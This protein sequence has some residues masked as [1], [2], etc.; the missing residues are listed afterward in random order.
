VLQFE[1]T[2]A[3][4]LTVGTDVTVQNGGT[5]Q[6]NP[7]GTQTGHSL[8]IAGN[9]T[10]NGTL[11]FSTNADT[12]GAGIVFTGAANNTF[13]GSGATTDIRLLTINKG[14]SNTNVLELNPSNF[15]VRGVTTDTVVG[16]WLTLTNGTLKLS[17]MFSG[18]SRVFTSAAYTIATNVG[19]WLNNPNYTV[20]G[21]TGSSTLN[22]LLHVSQGTFNI[23]TTT[24]NA[25]GFST[26]S[27]VVVDGGTVNTTGRFG[28]AAAGNVINY[29]QSAGTITVNTIGN[30]SATLG[31][32]DLGTSVSSSVN[33]SG[34]TIVAQLAASA[35]DYRN[36]A[37]NGIP[38]VTGGTLQLG[39]AA[40]G[41]AKSFNIRGV[42]PNL[43]I[44]NTSANHT[45]T[46]TSSPVSFNNSSLDI[47]INAGN[48]L[49]TANAIFLMVGSTVTN[50]GTLTSSGANSNFIWLDN[51]QGLQTYTGTGVTTA[52]VTDM[53]VESTGLTFTSTNQFITN[54]I[55]L[56]AG[57]VTNSNHITLGTGGATTEVV[58]IGN[59]TTPTAAGTF[60]VAPVFNL[61]TGG[62]ILLY[63]RT[64]SARVAGPEIN[65]ARTLAIL[66]YDENDPTH[67]LSLDADLSVIGTTTL[68]NGRLVT[69]PNNFIVGAVARTN[70]YVDGNLRKSLGAA[71]SVTFE[72]GTANGYTPVNVNATAGTFPAS[73]TVASVQSQAPNIFPT[74]KA[75]DRYWNVSAPNIT[76]ADLTFSYLDPDLPGTLTEANLVLYRLDGATYTNL[77]GT[78][79]TA[80]NTLTATGIGTFGLFTLAEPGETFLL[81]A[82]LSVTKTDGVTTATPGGSVTYTITASSAGPDNVTGAT[83]ADTFPASLTCTWTCTG[84]G[85]GTCTAAGSGNIDDLADLPSGGSTTY[86]ASCTIS[87]TAT[88]TLSNTATVT[89]P[90][91]VDDETPANNS[92][93]DT[94]TLVSF[95]DLAITKTDGVTSATPGGSVTYTITASNA[96]PSSATGATIADTFP[97]N[98]TC[99]WTC[100][101]TAGGTCTASGAGNISD[102]IDLPSGG[103]TTY[104]ASCTISAAATGTLSNTAT[105]TAPDG[106]TDPTPGNNSA[107]D[108]D[109]LTPSADLA[110][111]NTDGVT[112]TTPHG[113]VTYTITASNAGPSNATGATIADTFPAGATCTWTC[114]GAGG[115]TC[116]ASGSGNLNDIVNLPSGGSITYTAS[117]SLA[118]TAGGTLSD[119]ATVV[120]P[121]GVNDPV[122]ENN[123]ATD[124]DTVNSAALTVTVDDGHGYVRVGQLRNYLL[125]IS[126]AGPDDATDIAIDETLSS[127]FE[128]GATEWSCIGGDGG[129]SCTA[130]GT[131]PLV[132]SGIVIPVSRSLTWLVSVP[133]SFDTDEDTADNT[134]D[135]TTSFDPNSP[136]V[137]TDSDTIVIFRDGFD[138]AFADGSDLAPAVASQAPALTAMMHPLAVGQSL[139]FTLPATAGANAVDVLVQAR[140]PDGS[141]FRVE[142]LNVGKQPSVRVVSIDLLG[143][144][145]A[146]TWT[147][148]QNGGTVVIGLAGDTGTK[149]LLETQSAE[150]TLQLSAKTLEVYQV[151]AADAAASIIE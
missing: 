20:A 93:N 108:N 54:R 9:L 104:T 30:T 59:T 50:N 132:D 100:A 128:A 56:F 123:S 150:T 18:T 39:N 130:S 35:I 45:A 111:T 13:G 76:S 44:T 78:P 99:T 122:P 66:Q 68:A 46:F 71:A 144:E 58:Q 105:V 16:G 63:L 148:A 32:F 106:V 84:T 14:T 57:S 143:V 31:S 140:A 135:V 98:L 51:G 89:A 82:D 115:G 1:Q 55:N 22:G 118:V 96:G 7:A 149:A 40:S 17:G 49:N 145:R 19:F 74:D 119:T 86:T 37:G 6:S 67:T 146:S 131:G 117:C 137:V 34:G 133:I 112:S 102:T 94:D 62:E 52:P 8:S 116:T 3:R 121:A 125:K 124:T 110:I 88:G 33:V 80:A 2:T 10:N 113:N 136:Y 61:G 90:A 147:A 91:G 139:S 60:D 129:A 73:V 87:P 72:V 92:A 120:A 29:S 25:L 48:T 4:T 77:G 85:G 64:G 5:L 43:V 75:I 27:T 69:G 70:G 151:M 53:W 21:Q 26:G 36:Q 127:A 138:V 109:T 101:G 41:A 126:N 79:N 95:A 97:A 38:S 28:V 15:T 81:H 12:A 103:S 42:V 83:V 141:G 11:D 24:G 134:F 23:G 142:R 114:V 65:P 47:T 107:T